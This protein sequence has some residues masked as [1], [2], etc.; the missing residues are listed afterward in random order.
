MKMNGRMRIFLFFSFTGVLGCLY[1]KHT[2]HVL[3]PKEEADP[4]HISYARNACAAILQIAF[5]FFG[6]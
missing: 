2:R 6:V 4:S 3:F 1:L 5:L